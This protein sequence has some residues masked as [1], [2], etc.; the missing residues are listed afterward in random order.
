ME[1]L[2]TFIYLVQNEHQVTDGSETVVGHVMS[3]Q[4][5]HITGPKVAA[6]ITPG[7]KSITWTR[8]GV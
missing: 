8:L 2:Y 4:R 3:P 5:E 7:V 6:L 1:L